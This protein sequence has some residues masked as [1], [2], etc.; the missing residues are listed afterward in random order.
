M[1][2]EKSKYHISPLAPLSFFLHSLEFPPHRMDVRRI[3]AL[4][5]CVS[6][7]TI[8]VWKR[9]HRVTSS[10]LRRVGT[11]GALGVTEGQQLRSVRKELKKEIN[12]SMPFE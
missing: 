11:A 9:M 12:Q 2:A 7:V 4:C 5:C 3:L 1:L 8:V 6:A 10:G